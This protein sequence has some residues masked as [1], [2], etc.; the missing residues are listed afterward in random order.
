MNDEADKL[1]L[2]TIA[3]MKRQL[4][5]LGCHVQVLQVAVAA[6]GMKQGLAP[7]KVVA[8]L[9][10]LSRRMTE[11]AL[12]DIGET[13]PRAAELLGVGDFLRMVGPDNERQ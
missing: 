10:K 7:D 9:E 6:F 12:L 4:I 13:N 8:A 5:E 1:L 2:D 3:S 11:K